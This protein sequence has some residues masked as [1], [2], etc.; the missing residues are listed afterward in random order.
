METLNIKNG[1]LGTV[2]RLYMDHN[3]TDLFIDIIETQSD[4]TIW[5]TRVELEVR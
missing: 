2:P 1:F 5:H 4:P 3:T